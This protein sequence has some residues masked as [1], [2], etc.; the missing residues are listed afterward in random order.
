MFFLF[1]EV[2]SRGS[3]QIITTHWA[4][5]LRKPRRHDSEIYLVNLLDDGCDC[6]AWQSPMRCF[7]DHFIPLSDNILHSMFLLLCPVPVIF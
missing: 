2:S 6:S 3:S 4:S 7:E 5:T 1:L